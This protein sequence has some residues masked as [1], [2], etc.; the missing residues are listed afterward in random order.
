MTDRRRISDP[1]EYSKFVRRSQKIAQDRGSTLSVEYLK[2]AQE[3]YR[4]LA[5]KVPH[6]WKAVMGRKYLLPTYRQKD[7]VNQDTYSYLVLDNL[8]DFGQGYAE[9][10]DK[11]RD[12]VSLSHYVAFLRQ[13]ECDRPTYWLE[14]E[15]AGPMVRTKLPDDYMISDIQ[16]RWPAFRVYLPK[17]LLTL[18]RAGGINSI[19]YLDIMRVNKGESY[20]LP[21]KIKEDLWKLYAFQNPI[22]KND[23]NGFAVC[24]VIDMD[25]PESA[26][27]YTGNSPLDDVTVK[28][29][30]DAVGHELNQNSPSDEIDNNLIHRMLKLGL[31]I[32]LFMSSYPLEYDTH[33]E[34]AVVR[35][36]R[37]EGGRTLPGLYKA[38]FVGASQIRPKYTPGTHAGSGPPQMAQWRSGHW[39]R[40]WFGPKKG[41]HRLQWIGLYHTGTAEEAGPAP[42]HTV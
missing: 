32:L 18:E 20:T 35:K 17:G 28:R 23:F 2:N 10:F 12:E 29:L 27:G 5:K 21:P 15:L 30:L 11:M 24:G 16:W 26:I 22:Y 33:P 1:I 19:V 38:K 36:P 4:K 25:D 8:V 31:N 41:Q 7:Y 14:T 13:I 40:I 9:K 39:K 6:L 34:Q 37:Q 42:S 3:R